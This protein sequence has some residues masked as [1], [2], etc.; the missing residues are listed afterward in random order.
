[1]SLSMLFNSTV[2]VFWALGL[3]SYAMKTRQYWL[4]VVSWLMLI[5]VEIFL[6]SDKHEFPKNVEVA[7]SILLF[8][9]IVGLV[10]YFIKKH[11][12]EID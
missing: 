8:A 5:P 11:R 12:G 1:M 2:L 6:L 9:L 7:L 10:V 3:V 4:V